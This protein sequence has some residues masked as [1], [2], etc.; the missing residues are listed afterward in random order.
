ML[1]EAQE[2]IQDITAHDCGP[3]QGY[4]P[5]PTPPISSPTQQFT[6]ESGAAS[7]GVNIWV[8]D[9]WV[10]FHGPGQHCELWTASSLS[11]LAAL[12]LN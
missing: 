10:D 6:L 2:A 8:G 3:P 5:G 7:V 11:S 9:K 4:V 12:Q 1:F